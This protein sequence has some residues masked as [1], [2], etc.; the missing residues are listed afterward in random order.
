M[1]QVG[2]NLGNL[3]AKERK[4][5]KEQTLYFYAFSALFHG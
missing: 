2:S 3:A 5:R 4:E 1:K